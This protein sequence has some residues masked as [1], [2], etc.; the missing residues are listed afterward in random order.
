MVVVS[1]A[2]PL[3]RPPPEAGA[4]AGPQQQQQQQQHAATAA[5]TIGG[6]GAGH[7]QQQKQAAAP[8][9]GGGAL[10]GAAVSRSSGVDE[11][12]APICVSCGE[13]VVRAVLHSK[14]DAIPFVYR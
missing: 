5:P 12:F 14:H 3:A 10:S 2:F 6:G 4:G 13:T 9:I 1:R 8:T 7:G 11:V